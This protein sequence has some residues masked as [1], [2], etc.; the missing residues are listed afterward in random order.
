MK[1][2]QVD[3]FQ[4]DITSKDSVNS[5]IISIIT[6]Y[7]KI[8]ALVNNAYPKNKNYGNHFFDV[9]YNDFIDNLGMNLGGYFL[10]SQQFAKIFYK[11]KYGN[12][13]NISSIYG[14]IAP[15]FEIYENTLMTTPVL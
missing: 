14:V 15:K 13:I 1:T 2:N 11:Q 9:S 12:I 3:F 7:N 4:M 6:K 10:T 8:D 5:A